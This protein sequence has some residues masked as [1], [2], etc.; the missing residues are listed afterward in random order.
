MKMKIL[1]TVAITL[2]ITLVFLALLVALAI[3]AEVVGEW[4]FIPIFG[5]LLL[6]FGIACVVYQY[7][8]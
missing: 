8:D 1:K 4:L 6:F 5:V 7:L 2:G 3:I